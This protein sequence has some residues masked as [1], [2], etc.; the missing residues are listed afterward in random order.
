MLKLQI[1][2]VYFNTCT[3]Y[4]TQRISKYLIMNYEIRTELYAHK[5]VYSN[6]NNDIKLTLIKKLILIK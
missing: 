5:N 2:N 6:V 3:G 1:Q 4:T